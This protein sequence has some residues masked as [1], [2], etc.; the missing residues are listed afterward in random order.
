MQDY[1]IPLNVSVEMIMVLMVK[2]TIANV[3]HL[4]LQ[5]ANKV[6]VELGGTLSMKLAI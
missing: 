6:V 1:N 5:R 3:A 4:V 2:S